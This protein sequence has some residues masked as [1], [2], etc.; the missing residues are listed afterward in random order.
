MNIFYEESGQFKVAAIVQKNDA[1]YQVDTQHG[2]RTKVKAN[3]VFTEFSGDMAAF[4]EKAQADAAEI[5]TDLL[6]EVCGEDE[7]SAEAIA[8]EYF[9]HAP[10]QAELA[11]TLIALY[12]A[13]MYFYKKAKGV[14]KAAPE[15]TLKQALAAIERKKQQDAQIDAWAAALQAGEMPSEIAADLKTILHAPDKQAL[16]YKAFIKAADALKLQPYDLAKQTGAV[17]SLPQYLL[18]AFE[19][20]H[21]PQGAALADMEVAPLPELPQADVAAFSIDDESTTEVDDALSLTDLGNGLKRVGIHI[22]APSLAIESGSAIEKTVMNR[23]ST[24][25]FPDGKIT[26]LPENWIAAFSLDEGAYRPAVSIYFDV[27]AEFNL[28]GEPVNKIEA[29][30]IAENLRIQAI[31][32]HFNA[33]TGLDAAGEAMFN[34]HQDLIWFHQFAI[35]RQ[36]ARGKYEENRAPQYDYSVEV[37]SDGIVSVTRRERGSPIDTLVSEMMILANSTWAQMLDENDLPGLFRV[38]PSGKVRMSTQS[39]PHIGMGVQHYGWFTSPLRRA[40]DYINQKQ[41]I[42][43]I[44]EHSEA[45]FHKNDAELFAALRDFDTAYAAYAD[46]QRQMEA[47]WSLVYLEQQGTKELTATVLKEDLVRIEGLPLVTR[48][49]GIPFDTLPKSQVLLNITGLD[50]E[51]QFIGL[52]YVKAVAPQI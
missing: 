34:H 27:D 11:A 17:T 22:A 18:D 30:N 14:F 48:A 28:V 13:P 25:Y 15:E 38:Q 3:N 9:G 36:K 49:V 39:E 40:A 10:S 26:M 37:A 31:E 50:S 20:K 24:A 42:S 32:P 12:A 2:K 35:A 45:L 16:T 47:Y 52:N 7:F 4:L 29:V 44:D 43:L 33:E 5:D 41:L 19:M 8:E 1:T 46:F 6:W 21:Y 23:L 51:K